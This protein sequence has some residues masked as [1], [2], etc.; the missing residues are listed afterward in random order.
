[1]YKYNFLPD[2]FRSFSKLRLLRFQ[3]QARLASLKHRISKRQAFKLTEP[4][5]EAPVSK[6]PIEMAAI[7]FVK[8]ETDFAYDNNVPINGF[9]LLKNTV[10]SRNS[11]QSTS[12]NFGDSAITSCLKLHRRHMAR[13]N[14]LL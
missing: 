3:A 7:L 12:R 1:M 13:Y 5:L 11:F 6:E 8:T 14:H 2:T 10:H 4:Q 9:I